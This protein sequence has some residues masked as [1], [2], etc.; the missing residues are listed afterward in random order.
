MDLERPTGEDVDLAEVAMCLSNICRFAG[1]VLRY[2]SVAEH[3]Y[4]IS[5]W[6]EVEHPQE[7]RLH[8]AGLLHDA[9]EAYLG[10]ITYPVQQLLFEHSVGAKEAWHAAKARIDLLVCEAAGLDPEWL[11]DPRI[12]EAD[13]R[14][15][16]DERAALMDRADED[17]DVD[18]LAPLDVPI[19]GWNPTR[20]RRVWQARL[21]DLMERM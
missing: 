17:W 15:L 14:I 21:R 19:K 20:A 2:Y 11:A 9:H 4:L 5:R 8:L 13:L 12:R 1:G 10:D 6:L 18:G 3:S 7:P 16:L